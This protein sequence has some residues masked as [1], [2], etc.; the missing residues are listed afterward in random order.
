MLFHAFHPA[1][2]LLLF[3]LRCT[4]AALPA[5]PAVSLL[6]S[7]PPSLSLLLLL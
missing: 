4:L 3:R 2:S 1:L 5:Y 7:L 6:F